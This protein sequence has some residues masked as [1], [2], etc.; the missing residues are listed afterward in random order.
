[1]E[2]QFRMKHI[3]FSVLLVVILLL[4]LFSYYP[5]QAKKSYK[6]YVHK[7]S[8]LYTNSK[9]SKQFIRYVPINAKLTT[10]S[11]KSSKMYKVTYGGQTGYVYRSNLWTRRT[12]IGRYIH[13]TSYLYSSRDG[14]KQRIW[15]I[16]VNK[17]LTTDSNMNSTM[18]H[19]NYNGRRGYVYK[20]NLSPYKT[21]VVKYVK[22]ASRQYKDYNHTRRY[23]GTIPLGTRLETQSPQSNK[24]YWV[25]YNGRKS[26]VYASNLSNSVTSVTISENQL[27]V[28][29]YGLIGE[30]GTHALWNTPSGTDGAH[31]FASLSQYNDG[32]PLN[33]LKEAKV[34][35]TEWYQIQFNSSTTA[36]VVKSAIKTTFRELPALS[37]VIGINNVNAQVYSQPVERDNFALKDDYNNNVTLKVFAVALSVDQVAVIDNQHW[38][39]LKK[40]TAGTSVGWVKADGNLN[41]SSVS[42]TADFNYLNSVKVVSSSYPIFNDNNEFITYSNDY[43]KN[44]Y[45]VNAEK[46]I[47][48]D[49]MYRLNGVGWISGR[50]LIVSGNQRKSYNVFNQGKDGTIYL[51][52][53]I[54][55]SNYPA[56]KSG[57]TLLNDAYK[58][59]MLEVIDQKQTSDG[60]TWDFLKYNDW[61]DQQGKDIYIGWVRDD[62]LEA[63]ADATN[64]FRQ[65]PVLTI[66]YSV[67]QQGL[68]Y[69][70][71]GQYFV[72]FD[73]GSGLGSV[74]LY[75]NNARKVADSALQNFGHTCALSYDP[76]SHKIFEVNSA[77]ITPELNILN[78]DSSSK[79]I[80][81][82]KSIPLPDSVKYVAMMAVKD[83][84]T[85]ILMTEKYAD[86]ETFYI[87]HLDDDGNISGDIKMAQLGDMG[88]VQGMQYFDGNLYFM[89]NDYLTVL[90]EQSVEDTANNPN[91]HSIN[92]KQRYH[93]SIPNQDPAE[94]E[95]LTVIPEESNDQLVTLSVGFHN[96]EIYKLQLPVN[97]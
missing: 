83:K 42:S 19:V 26:Y 79:K 76:S 68:A 16:A 25:S 81:V 82:T 70:S 6:Y 43:L 86:K 91:G 51:N 71:D 46:V 49:M 27:P 88:V 77:G 11:K 97:K 61:F 80:T 33:I 41:Y 3:Y 13:K 48:G 24:L 5:A 31:T 20:S 72:G 59:K 52:Q 63:L 78:Y 8:K 32:H 2:G 65:Q 40:Y 9:S 12:T 93:Y 15:K 84:N 4:S 22:K 87:V 58:N 29:T 7:T 21:T 73:E 30:A 1:M 64:S 38:V 85:L 35:T 89:A 90:D 55:N 60:T 75:D 69:Y 67:S 62:S 96:H 54:N 23:S 37:K 18:Y 36:W 95:G 56:N 28:N 47:N 66:P 14:S 94:S 44:V 45:S 92:I 50:A 53:E 10:T 34:G 57:L 39:H 74:K 17:S